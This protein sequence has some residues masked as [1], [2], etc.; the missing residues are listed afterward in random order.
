M[1]AGVAKA[2]SL[3][4]TARRDDNLVTWQEHDLPS[5]LELLSEQHVFCFVWKLGVDSEPI[6]IAEN[7]LSYRKVRP[8]EERVSQA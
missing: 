5:L 8:A 6:D 1:M 2:L 7:V 4:Q 3:V